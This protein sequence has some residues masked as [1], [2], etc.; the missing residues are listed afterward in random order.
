MEGGAAG[1]DTAPCG[2][3]L[4][5]GLPIDSSVA[6]LITAQLWVLVQEAPDPIYF[7][8]NSTGIAVSSR[9]SYPPAL[10][11][12]ALPS[13]CSTAA[14][15]GTRRRRPSSR[16]RACH[17]VP[18]PVQK[19]NSKFGNEPEAVAVY[20]M[21]QGVQKYCPIYTL[22][23]GNAF[24]EA[25][26]L[27][28]AGSPVSARPRQQHAGTAV[29][30]PAARDGNSTARTRCTEGLARL[31]M[32]CAAGSGGRG[33]SSLALTPGAAR[34][35]P[36]A[37]SRPSAPASAG[38]ARV[39]AIEH[40]H[41]PPAVAAAGGHAGQR[42]RHLPQADAREDGHHGGWWKHLGRVRAHAR[43]APLAR[44][45]PAAPVVAGISRL[46][47]VSWRRRPSLD[48][49]TAHG[50]APLVHGAAMPAA[51]TQQSVG[52]HTPGARPA[53]RPSTWPSTL[54][55]RRRT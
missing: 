48:S 23:V 6:E 55:A 3:R 35:S 2:L 52:G 1:P 36:A 34:A 54:G 38:Q 28:A 46:P 41:D 13:A 25:A 30:R 24:G 33:V 4:S 18:A 5:Q 47:A 31:A 50:G 37:D 17:G 8:I 26:L 39:A 19:S 44:H 40:H 49:S 16:V 51:G 42:H 7:Y 27:L 12:P 22:A 43:G 11:C 53:R 20:Q 29:G 10:P 15:V 45:A 21:M 14:A 32:G 9:R